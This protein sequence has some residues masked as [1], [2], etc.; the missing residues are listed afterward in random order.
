MTIQDLTLILRDQHE[1]PI[2]G[3]AVMLTR[4][5][6][7]IATGTTGNDGRS[8]ITAIQSG[9]GYKFSVS[10]PGIVDSDESSVFEVF[11]TGLAQ[12]R[13][14]TSFANETLSVSIT[15]LCQVRY[16]LTGSAGGE[17]VKIR[18]GV[19]GSKGTNEWLN[20]ST[21]NGPLPDWL[22]FRCRAGERIKVYIERVTGHVSHVL[23]QGS[24][25]VPAQESVDLTELV[26][27]P[28]KTLVGSYG[29]R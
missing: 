11:P 9:T 22:T 15:T 24:F 10:K 2:G 23:V 13:D 14:M 8:V 16:A 7:I 4:N 3:A 18:A 17:E 6:G 25:I 19:V 1:E 21:E 20:H 28:D 29:N 26:E 27:V 5:G 12:T